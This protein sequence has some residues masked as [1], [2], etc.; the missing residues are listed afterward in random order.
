MAPTRPARGLLSDK[1]SLR[2][3]KT[4]GCWV[5]SSQGAMQTCSCKCSEDKG[6]L[7]TG[8]WGA[9]EYVCAHVLIPCC[10]QSLKASALFLLP[11][12]VVG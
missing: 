6:F 3:T 1:R 7:C 12:I 8:L 2:F 4:E 10:R 9:H 11:V 5:S